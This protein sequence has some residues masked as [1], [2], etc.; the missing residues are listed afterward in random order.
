MAVAT[1]ASLI[2]DFAWYFAG[3]RHGRRVMRLMCKLTSHR[4]WPLASAG[5]TPPAVVQFGVWGGS[6]AAVADK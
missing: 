3:A 5:L 4:I 6:N 2:A 1:A